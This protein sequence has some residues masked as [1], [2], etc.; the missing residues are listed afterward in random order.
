MIVNV[1][2]FPSVTVVA[3]LGVIV[4]PSPS[5]EALT[6]NSALWISSPGVIS[7][8][9]S[10][11][12]SFVSPS[13]VKTPDPAFSA[14]ISKSTVLVTFASVFPA[15]TDP[16]LIFPASSFHAKLLLADPLL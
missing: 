6:V 16:A 8:I 7:N 1:T 11:G 2:S 3:P 10:C 14:T 13:N 9:S 15:T 12:A 4:P 5:T